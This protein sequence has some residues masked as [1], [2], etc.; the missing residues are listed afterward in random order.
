MKKSYLFVVLAV[1]FAIALFPVSSNAGTLMIG[2][3]GWYAFW[4]S[5]IGEQFSGM[6]DEEIVEYLKDPAGGNSDDARLSSD[7]ELGRGILVGPLLSYQ[8]DDKLW[9]VSFA[10]MHFGSFSQEADVTASTFDGATWENLDA[11]YKLELNRREY[12]FAVT[13]SLTENFKVFVGYKHQITEQKFKGE[14]PW[15][16]EFDIYEVD[17]TLKIP[18]AGIGY[19][20]PLTDKLFFGAQLGLLYVMPTV[21]FTDKFSDDAGNYSIDGDP[22]DGEEFEKDFDSTLGFNGE[23]AI[24]YLVGESLIVQAGYRYQQMRFKKGG[25]I[26]FDEWDTFHGVTLT[27]V[28]LLAL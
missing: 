26:D 1:V 15:G 12:D 17:V 22:V 13:R 25:D 23:L 10:L 8:T 16:N 2:V 21:E 9:S 11:K 27:A 19:V 6:A 4:D 28:Y 5:A 3:K 14:D 24:S 18:T 7:I 20:H